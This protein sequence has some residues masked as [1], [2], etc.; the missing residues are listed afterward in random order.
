MRLPLSV[1]SPILYGTARVPELQGSAAMQ[2]EGGA[3][4]CARATP[5]V[6]WTHPGWT[7]PGMRAGVVS[8]LQ[9]PLWQEASGHRE[10]G[11]GCLLSQWLEH[12]GLGSSGQDYRI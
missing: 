10:E 8:T 5:L 1:E 9:R 7:L 4:A 2:E 11:G 12:R 6:P 3:A